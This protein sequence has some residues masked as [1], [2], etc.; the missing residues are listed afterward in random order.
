MVGS[1][2]KNLGFRKSW[3]NDEYLGLLNLGE[4]LQKNFAKFGNDY[5]N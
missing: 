1:H 2:D 5:S 3:H 4:P